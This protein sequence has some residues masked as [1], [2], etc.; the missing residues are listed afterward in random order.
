MIGFLNATSLDGYR[1]MVKAFRQ[2]LQKSGYVEGRM[3]RLGWAE[4]R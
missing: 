2:G 3:W 1:P 4:S